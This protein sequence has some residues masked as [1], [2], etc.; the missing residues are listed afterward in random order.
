MAARKSAA[1]QEGEG[2]KPF[3]D[4]DADGADESRTVTVDGNAYVLTTQADL[5]LANQENLSRF[6]V[7]LGEIRGWQADGDGMLT[8]EQEAVLH[9]LELRICRIALPD[10]PES[11]FAGADAKYQRRRTRLIERFTEAVDM[12]PFLDRLTQRL[13]PQLLAAMQMA[14]ELQSQQTRLRAVPGSASSSTANETP[15]S[16]P[17]SSSKAEAA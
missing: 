4:L 5:S 11:A 12:T 13:R 17:D 7:Q 9:N 2:R 15:D 3:L 10:A 1:P 8:D 6:F 14:R 16:S